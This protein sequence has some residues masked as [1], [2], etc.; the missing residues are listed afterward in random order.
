MKDRKWRRVSRV[1]GKVGLVLLTIFLLV[2]YLIPLSKPTSASV[3]PFENSSLQQVNGVSFHYRL[4]TPPGTTAKGKLVFIHGLGG[5]T[6][7][8]EELAPFIASQGYLVV[9]V[10]LPG[11]GYS[12]RSLGF[13]H[14]QTNRS[15]HVW[16]LLALLEDR[17]FAK[18]ATQPWHLL[19]HSMGG[20][21]VAAMALQEPS[22]TASLIFLDAALS[23]TKQGGFLIRFAP[24]R[25]W[26]QVVGE[27]ILIKEGPIKSFLATSYGREPSPQE[28]AGYLQPLRLPGTARC[29]SDIFR[30]SKNEAFARLAEL[31]SPTLALWGEK[32]TMV[33]L[34]ELE[35]LKTVLPTLSS[36]II[37]GA[38][39][40]PMETHMSTVA[41]ILLVW[42]AGQD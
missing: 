39:H 9:S 40:C 30:T 38:A 22:R 31:R 16:Q 11:F 37:K 20:G 8:F 12:D 14:S 10:D 42:L 4:Y 1:V 41:D 28:V 29:F 17:L 2:P 6:F 33:P 27:Y 21:T 18:E 32:D 26:V 35:K 15:K 7:S 25:Q 3:L 36:H 23:D 5:S 13:D 34:S 19:G 24:L